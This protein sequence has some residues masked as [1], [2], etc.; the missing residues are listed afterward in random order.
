MTREESIWGSGWTH[1]RK[2]VY[3]TWLAYE[4][5]RRFADYA[6]SVHNF[7]DARYEQ[8]A[9]VVGNVGSQT[10]DVLASCGTFAACELLLTVPACIALYKFFEQDNL[11]D[12]KLERGLKRIL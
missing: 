3:P 9:Q 7:L 12:T 6:E 4:A 5:S 8:I 10:L 1:V 11:T 2:W